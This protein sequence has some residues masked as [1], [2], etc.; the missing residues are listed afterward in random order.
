MADETLSQQAASLAE[1]AEAIRKY[2]KLTVESVIETGRHLTEAKKLVGHGNWLPWLEREFAWTEQTALNF[3]RVAE[4]SKSKSVLDLNTPLSALYLLAREDTP[5]EAV[6]EIAERSARGERTSLSDAQ[7][8]VAKARAVRI[9][10]EPGKVA[11]V[12][13]SMANLGRQAAA[14]HADRPVVTN[15]RDQ[16][17]RGTAKT[18]VDALLNVDCE[19]DHECVDD[20]VAFLLEP[21]NEARLARVRKVLGFAFRLK[22]ALDRA[23]PRPPYLRPL[24]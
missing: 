14:I 21:G 2:A 4:L 19:L 22:D 23:A 9:V 15:L 7:R 20:M 17:I 13:A 5:P 3:M 16:F 10:S 8:T 12:H 6:E 1:H 18:T 11:D 24:N